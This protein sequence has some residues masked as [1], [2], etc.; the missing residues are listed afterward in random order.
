[1]RSF[2]GRKDMGNTGPERLI[3]DKL[4]LLD[5]AQREIWSGESGL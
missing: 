3:L 2:T 5:M 1:M 4:D